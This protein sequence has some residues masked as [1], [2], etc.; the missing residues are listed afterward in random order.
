MKAQWVCNNEAVHMANHRA[1]L[2]WECSQL[3]GVCN[4]K[5]SWWEVENSKR[6]EVLSC[7]ALH[8]R[9]YFLSETVSVLFTFSINSGPHWTVWDT[10][11]WSCCCYSY[12]QLMTFV[13]ETQGMCENCS[14]CTSGLCCAPAAAPTNGSFPPSQHLEKKITFPICQHQLKTENS[15]VHSP[16]ASLQQRLLIAEAWCELG[17]PLEKSKRSATASPT[18]CIKFFSN[19]LRNLFARRAVIIDLYDW[20]QVHLCGHVHVHW[21]Q[22]EAL[23]SGRCLLTEALCKSRPRDYIS[24]WT[25][26]TYRKI[27]GSCI[28]SANLRFKFHLMK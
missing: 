4:V 18:L 10:P 13:W 17:K 5:T 2:P 19:N 23:Q 6:K 24:C 26:L 27:H 25:V 15:K 28:W 8:P 20:V 3:L 16:L 12:H 1:A 9:D 21:Q 22:K 14:S 7:R 11:L